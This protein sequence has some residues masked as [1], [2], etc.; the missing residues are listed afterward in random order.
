MLDHEPKKQQFVGERVLCVVNGRE[1]RKK[2]ER[3]TCGVKH[4]EAAKDSRV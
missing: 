3:M 1:E 2:G 4:P